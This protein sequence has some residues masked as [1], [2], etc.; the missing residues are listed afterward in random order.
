LNPDH[1][2]S[3]DK[4]LLAQSIT[5]DTEAF[6]ALMKRHE[7]RIFNLAL[8]IMG[9]RAD[10]LD[11]SQDAF[12]SAY[13]QASSFRGDS[14]VGTWLYRIAVNACKDL[15]RKRSRWV[16]QDEHTLE[17][18]EPSDAR[19]ESIVTDRMVIREA[20]ARLP[21]E[22]REAVVM[23]DIGGIPYDEIATLTGTQIG[24]VK[25][26]ISRGRRRLAEL[27]EHPEHPGTSKE[28]R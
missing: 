20:L 17:L 12:I 15:L 3:S 11:A 7:E 8:R 24:T 16:A 19:L 21:D 10:A 4:E 28:V 6:G 27:M 14:A 26:R 5:G 2:D 13:R 25:S 23:H 18:L 9:D 1:G 22:Y